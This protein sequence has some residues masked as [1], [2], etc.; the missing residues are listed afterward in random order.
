[1]NRAIPADVSSPREWHQSAGQI[2]PS[3][4]QPFHDPF[5]EAPD[6]PDNLSG[7]TEALQE[8]KMVQI[9]KENDRQNRS[10][11]RRQVSADLRRLAMAAT[12][13]RDLLPG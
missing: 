5:R 1:M 11:A 10:W 6:L 3:R 8:L 7:G 9:S 2:T 13:N 12:R 4:Y